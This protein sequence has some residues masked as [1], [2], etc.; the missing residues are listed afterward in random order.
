MEGELR[1]GQAQVAG[2]FAHAAFPAAEGLDHLQADRFGQGLEQRPGLIRRERLGL[3]GHGGGGSGGRAHV[4]HNTRSI[5][6][7]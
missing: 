2:E 1:L 6:S 4:I 7:S 5:N 3:W